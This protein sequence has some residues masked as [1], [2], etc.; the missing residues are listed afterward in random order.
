MTYTHHYITILSLARERIKINRELIS[1]EDLIK[2]GNQA[3]HLLENESWTVFFD[4]LLT[5]S[6]L[7][8][9]D[10]HNKIDYIIYETGI[11]GR[12]DSTNFLINPSL[13][14]ITSISLDHQR[15]LGN[16]IEEIAS[17]KAGIIK[18][19]VPLFISNN[20]IKSVKNIFQQECIK[21]NSE[22]YEVPVNM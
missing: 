11:G 4:Y 5:I 9:N 22:I 14:I 7:Y 17:Q 3:L 10:H 15:L 18:N 13:C 6:I 21:F 19:K 8:F 12:Y 20:Q 16:S 2:Y 1:Q